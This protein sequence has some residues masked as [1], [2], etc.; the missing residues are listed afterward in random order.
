MEGMDEEL[1]T[2]LQHLREFG[3]VFLRRR[4][5]G[6][7]YPTRLV[8]NITSG[9]KKMLDEEIDGNLVVETNSRVYAYSPTALQVSLLAIFC[10][11]ECRFPNMV[12]CSISRQSVR[13]AFLKGITAEQI[14]NYL[15]LHAHK[16]MTKCTPIIPKT[17]S[18]Q[19]QLWELERERLEYSEGVL[20]KDF[21]LQQDYSLLAN[22]AKSRGVLIY[23][24]SKSRTLVVSKKGNPVVKQFWKETQS[25]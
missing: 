9:E 13:R 23:A 3:F 8:L 2:F 19:I 12:V 10:D 25:K 5:S 24:D 6:R 22:Y 4:S 1:Q 17:V 21:I 16:Q 11:I 7:F 18:E 14:I 20:Y 15:K